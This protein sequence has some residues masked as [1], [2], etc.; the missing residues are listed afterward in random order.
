PPVVLCCGRDSPPGPLQPLGGPPL[1]DGFPL[2]AA[3][4][5]APG[6][7]PAGEA[8]AGPPATG[9]P[10]AREATAGPAA[11]RPAALPALAGPLEA[12][13]RQRL[14]L[15]VEDFLQFLEALGGVVVGQ[16]LLL[17]QAAELLE[18]LLLLLA[19]EA[20]GERLLGGQ[21]PELADQGGEV[22]LGVG[23]AKHSARAAGHAAHAAGHPAHAAGHA[24]HAAAG[25]A[26]GQA[27]PT[28][29]AAG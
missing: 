4:G 3:R 26:A 12:D 25:P 8:A 23:T 6:P 1:A 20:D 13:R 15:R 14:L 22:A 10:S 16:F 21:Q 19:V 17:V 7:P 18:D 9:K 29:H 27:S 2:G 11:A 5:P 24:A 28:A